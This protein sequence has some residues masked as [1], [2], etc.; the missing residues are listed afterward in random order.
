MKLHNSIVASNAG[1]NCAANPASA[2]RHG[3]YNVGFGDHTCPGQ[4][5]KPEAGASCRQRW[6]HPDDGAWLPKPGNEPRAGERGRVPCHRPT[7]RPATPGRGL[8][9]RGAFSFP[10]RDDGDRLPPQ[11]QRLIRARLAGRRS[12]SVRRGGIA[13]PDHRCRGTLR[14]GRQMNTG[15][16]GVR[17]FTVTA[18]DATG[19]RISKTV[20]YSVWVYVNP[21]RDIHGLQSQRI[22]MG[23]DYGGSG[24]LLAL[25]AGRVLGAHVNDEPPRRALGLLQRRREPGGSHVVYQLTDG[26]F[27]GSYVYVAEHVRVSVHAGEV[28][29][30]GQRIA[31]TEAASPIAGPAGVGPRL[32]S[33]WP[34]PSMSARV[35]IPAV[36]RRSRAVTSNALVGLGLGPGV[37]VDPP[38]QSMPVG[39]PIW[40]RWP[41]W[42][43]EGCRSPRHRRPSRRYLWLWRSMGDQHPA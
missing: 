40:L 39:W 13:R 32:I 5:L 30:A 42:R 23:V 1:S 22:D 35:V 18:V 36:G 2:I 8:R 17:E 4:D 31:L 28:V 12:L 14:A 29:R 7:R 20:R 10:C 25:G 41:G 24:P 11:G 16:V 38:R 19:Q 21:L 43:G 9:R 26:P 37:L 34:S 6:P 27:A 33:A 3:G 15:T